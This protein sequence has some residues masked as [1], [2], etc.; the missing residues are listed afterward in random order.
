MVGWLALI[1]C[2]EDPLPTSPS[3]EP[4]PSAPLPEGGPCEPSDLVFSDPV[5]LGG[6]VGDTFLAATGD[7]F[8]VT[9]LTDGLQILA[10][11][12]TSRGEVVQTVDV[13]DVVP[14]PSRAAW[15]VRRPDDFLVVWS[16]EFE[17]GWRSLAHDGALGEPVSLSVLPSTT[18]VSGEW[19]GGGL[20]LVLAKPSEPDR[21]T[22]YAPDGTVL[23]GPIDLPFSNRLGGVLSHD[24]A[25]GELV[26]LHT[27]QA[28]ERE[29]M[30]RVPVDPEVGPGDREVLYEAATL[31]AGS[32]LQRPQ[33]TLLA[34]DDAGLGAVLL[35]V[36]DG[37]IRSTLANPMRSHP[38]LAESDGC[39]ALAHQAS[40]GGL[41]LTLFD[42][43]LGP[44]TQTRLIDPGVELWGAHQLAYAPGRLAFAWSE[45][46]EDGIALW[47]QTAAL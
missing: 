4:V 17:L 30:W 16:T 41:A 29:Q 10:T 35:T 46:G 20:E 9:T 25:A 21:L 7:G 44:V 18:P 19:F 40:E 36:T 11:I 1:A 22:R 37:S 24:P 28:G 27:I 23:A 38:A 34:F 43:A 45:R 31:H 39:V 47:V 15:L 32:V 3:V 8:V 14:D 13:S 42:G 12:L 6:S 33:G 26:H 2:A 5:E